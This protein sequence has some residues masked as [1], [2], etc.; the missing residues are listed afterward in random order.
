MSFLT[1][2]QPEFD[3]IES[4][5]LNESTICF[6][7]KRFACVLCNESIRLLVLGLAVLTLWWLSLAYVDYHLV[8]FALSTSGS[9]LLVY[10]DD[11]VN[12][13]SDENGIK[14]LKAFLRTRFQTKD[15]GPLNY[16][17]IEVSRNHNRTSLSQ[18]RYCMDLPSDVIDLNQNF[19][20]LQWYQIWNWKRHDENI[21]YNPEKYRRVMGKLNYLTITRPNITFPLVVL[22]DLCHPQD[23]HIGTLSLTSQS[24]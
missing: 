5:F 10:V 23:L 2:L 18:R 21:F 19:L 24:I 4:Q 6:L 20:T 14:R 15:P 9:I 7:I 16:L 1:S 3:A 17:G 11:I 12:T 13:R 22:A 8:F